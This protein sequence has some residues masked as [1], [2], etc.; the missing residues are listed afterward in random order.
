MDLSSHMRESFFDGVYEREA[1]HLDGMQKCRQGG[2][3]ASQVEKRADG[4]NNIT[5][6]CIM[7]VQC[8]FKY[9]VI[10]SISHL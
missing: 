8:R 3:I 7:I 2:E 1:H 5:I 4:T 9:T 6:C 10:G